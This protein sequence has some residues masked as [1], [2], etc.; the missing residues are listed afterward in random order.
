MKRPMP[1]WRLEQRVLSRCE[2]FWRGHGT[3]AYTPAGMQHRAALWALT[4][5]K[6]K[7]AEFETVLEALSE[8]DHIES[9]ALRLWDGEREI[10]PS[11]HD[12]AAC[13]ADHLEVQS[14][15]ILQAVRALIPQQ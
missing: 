13:K 15:I 11:D 2:T 1:W 4:G 7:L 5:R 12:Y 14:G 9:G 8:R 6:P 10:L 3:D